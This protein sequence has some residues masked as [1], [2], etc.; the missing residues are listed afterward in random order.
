MTG[1]VTPHGQ[2]GQILCGPLQ[3]HG[4]Q[5]LLTQPSLRSLLLPRASAA[6][7]SPKRSR[8]TTSSPTNQQIPI[9]KHAAAANYVKY[10][11]VVAASSEKLK[12]GET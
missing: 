11:I 2:I 12:V 6:I 4:P 10:H 1:S 7:S 3:T 9:A 8:S 5:L